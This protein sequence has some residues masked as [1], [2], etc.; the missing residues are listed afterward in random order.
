MLTSMF[1]VPEVN[2]AGCQQFERGVRTK[3][4]WERRPGRRRNMGLTHDITTE[5]IPELRFRDIAAKV[6]G[7]GRNK[8]VLGNF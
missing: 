5:R 8:T 7:P 3:S 1:A 6:G 2:E 4:E